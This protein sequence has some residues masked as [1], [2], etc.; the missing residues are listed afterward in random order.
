[1]SSTLLHHAQTAPRLQSLYVQERDTSLSTTMC[2]LHISWRCSH[3]QIIWEF[4]RESPPRG[5]YGGRPC[6]NSVQRHGPTPATAAE[7]E[8]RDH[9]CQFSCCTADQANLDKQIRALEKEL[10]LRHGRNIPVFFLNKNQK[11]LKQ[12]RKQFKHLE[13][14]HKDRCEA[15][16]YGLE[17]VEGSEPYRAPTAETILEVEEEGLTRGHSH[18][19]SESGA[20]GFRPKTLRERSSEMR[21][22]KRMS[23]M[24]APP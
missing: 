7:E 2:R 6:S 24:S 23:A 3:S 17:W 18:T 13:R 1:V 9:C 16:Y 21:A 22:R 12:L 20:Q 5:T 10:D 8:F 15:L 4:C 11:A 19:R 14:R